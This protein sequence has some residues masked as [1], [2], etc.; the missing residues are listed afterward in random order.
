VW[1][2]NFGCSTMWVLW[3]MLPLVEVAFIKSV[4]C[5]SAERPRLWAVPC[6]VLRTVPAAAAT[7]LYMLQCVFAV[8]LAW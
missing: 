7:R 2:A 5:S 1:Q 8:L 3:E 6:R 4:C